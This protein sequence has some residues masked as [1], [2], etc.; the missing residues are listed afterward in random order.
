KE[1]V[2]QVET[3]VRQHAQIQATAEQKLS[4]LDGWLAARNIH[5]DLQQVI[6][7]PPPG[8]KSW[9]E[10]VGRH[11]V[12]WLEHA[13]GSVAEGI[14]VLLITLYLL[15][16][17]REMREGFQ[18]A[19][20]A[21]LRP[22]AEQWQTD[23]N[24]I[25]GGF[26]RGQAV[27]ALVLGAAAAVGCLLFGVHYWLLIGLFVVFASLIPVFGP[28]IGAVP[29]IISALLTPG[30]AI[31]TPVVRAV[32][33]LLLFIVINEGGSKILYPRL[34]GSALGLH[35]VMVLFVLFAGLEVGHLWGVL[36]AAPL[37]ALIGV[38]LAHLY[39]FW[40]GSPPL[41]ITQH[42]REGGRR[43]EEQGTP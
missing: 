27:L 29:A 43:A 15:I 11:V 5:V 8:V 38:T 10:A 35:E 9:G 14:I 4:D 41:S 7:H 26:V 30:G 19:M 12:G 40:L 1:L 18:R 37:T 36:F 24:H 21:R 42:L 23:A 2:Y 31:L 3:L 20:P 28:Y 16:Y 39:R 13:A 33:V 22:Y 32:L 6:T 25:L 17:S 34:V